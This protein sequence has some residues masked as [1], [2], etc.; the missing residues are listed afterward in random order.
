MEFSD[1]LEF[2]VWIQGLKAVSTEMFF[3]QLSCPTGD[4]C[5]ERYDLLQLQPFELFQL[6]ANLPN[7]AP[8]IEKV[9]TEV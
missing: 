7:I 8:S 4:I 6:V 1:S 3:S 5:C 2:H 9:A